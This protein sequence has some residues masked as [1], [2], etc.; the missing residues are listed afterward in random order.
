MGTK[1]LNSL[2]DIANQLRLSLNKQ[3]ETIYGD[4]NQYKVC[5]IPSNETQTFT[6]KLSLKQG[7]KL[8]DSELVKQVVDESKVIKSCKVRDHH[9]IYILK[10]GRITK[11]TTGDNLKETLDLITNFL[12]TKQHQSCCQDCG[13]E[14]TESFYNVS[15]VPTI[16]CDDC[17]RKHSD[18]I[19]ASEQA[20]E[21]KQENVVT[22]LVGG[23]LGSLLGVG[24]IIL[25]GQ[26][27][28]VS[29]LSG[30]IMAV[31]SLKGY[32]LLGGKLTNKGIIGTAIVMI[33][34]VYF[35]TRLD[36]SISLANFFQEMNFLM[37]FRMLPD[38]IREGYIEAS[39]YYWDLALVYIF[40]A[41]GAI[42][43]IIGM[44]KNK[45]AKGESYQMSA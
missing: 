37:A 29:A 10:V 24:A 42:P 34:M 11:N 8:P 2:E 28:Y 44:R 26:L 30:I 9:V 45:K 15:G 17:F 12:K 13:T 7:N 23:L 19:M 40:T 14:G 43:T 36:W 41:L 32:E 33:V 21:E 31:C 3:M 20:K 4:F 5:L 39:V 18:L 22:G 25:F 16:C 35:G 6:L 1:Y 27:G 38:L